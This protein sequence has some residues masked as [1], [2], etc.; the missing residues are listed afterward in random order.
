MLPDDPAELK[1]RLERALRR[2]NRERAAREQAESLL[3]AK[4]LELFHA[5]EALRQQAGQLEKTVHERTAALEIAL[6]QAETAAQA[7]SEFLA[8]MSHEIRTP[9]NGIIGLGE[10]L[11]GGDLNPGQARYARLL[12]QSGKALLGLVND[13][14]DFSKI[15]AGHLELE[16]SNFDLEEELAG[17]ASSFGLQ[18]EAKGL[19]L[20]SEFSDLPRLVL[21]DA[22]RLRQVVANLLSNA[23]KFTASGQIILRARIVASGDRWKLHVEVDD[24][25]IGIPPDKIKELFDPFTQA[26]SSTTRRFGGT[27]LGLA[28][29]RRLVK[30]MGGE[31]TARTNKQGATFSFSIFLDQVDPGLELLTS[32]CEQPSRT[33]PELK[34]LLVE[35]NQVNQVVALGLL[36]RLGREAD[37]APDGRQ[38]IEM[39]RRKNYD[40]ILMDMQLPGMDG[41]EATNKIRSLPID[42]QPIIVAL[43][44]NAMSE[45]RTRCIE[46]GMN[47]FLTKPIRV[48]QLRELLCGAC[49]LHDC[50]AHP[51]NP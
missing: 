8:T 17:L 3:E 7:R 22:L 23:I 36:R 30:A 45:D 32:D 34:I 44:A 24:S 18:A 37:C 40:L 11:E 51:Q 47:G 46:A 1:S 9:L 2:A 35:D 39:V 33:A 48:G 4:S 5:N 49:P 20:L 21:G 12:N 41:I 14:L 13:I 29:C 26:D 19:R 50:A 16:K 27:G 25:G 42:K 38:A 15:E 43:T 10:L 28:I 6:Q 31:I